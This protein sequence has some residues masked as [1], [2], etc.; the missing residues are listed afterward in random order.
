VVLLE[1]VDDGASVVVVVVVEGGVTGAGVVVVVITM[2]LPNWK[3]IANML[4]ISDCTR[5]IKNVKIS[6]RTAK[7]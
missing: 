4:E 2:S 3:L 6:S 1:V 5:G 7:T